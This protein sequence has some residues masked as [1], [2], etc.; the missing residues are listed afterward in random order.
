MAGVGLLQQLRVAGLTV[1][2]TG[3]QLSISPRDRLSDELRAAI[4][5][6]KPNLL[7]ALAADIDERIRAMARRWHYS[8]DDLADEMAFAASC[9]LA[10][11]RWIEH[12][13]A[14]WIGGIFHRLGDSK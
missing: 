5:S 9:P 10:S 3:G 13:E 14:Q 11:L 2:Q 8:P 12:D 7:T 1:V 6:D 4:R